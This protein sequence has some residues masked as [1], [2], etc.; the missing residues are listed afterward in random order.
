MQSLVGLATLL[1][2][3]SQTMCTLDPAHVVCAA[4]QELNELARWLFRKLSDQRYAAIEQ[5][6]FRPLTE[7]EE[8]HALARL[9]GLLSDRY[10]AASTFEVSS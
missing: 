1:C 7:Q 2:C 4:L 6:E 8:E 3:S 9:A 5:Q 10:A